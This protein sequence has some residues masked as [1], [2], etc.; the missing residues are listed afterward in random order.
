MNIFKKNYFKVFL[1]VFFGFI[2]FL[3]GLVLLPPLDRDESRFASASKNMIETK[4]FIGLKYQV[5]YYLGIRHMT[6]YGLTGYP[7]Y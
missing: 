7:P 1:F 6:K 5:H 2:I 3:Q 4:D